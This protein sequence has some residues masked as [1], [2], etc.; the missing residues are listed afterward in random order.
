VGYRASAGGCCGPVRKSARAATTSAAQITTLDNWHKRHTHYYRRWAV[1]CRT[2]L[3]LIPSVV[4]VPLAISHDEA[5]VAWSTGS[6]CKNTAE[7]QRLLP[8]HPFVCI[9]QSQSS[10]HSEHLEQWKHGGHGQ[11]CP[12]QN[13]DLRL[14][15]SDN[16]LNTTY[17]GTLKEVT[18]IMINV[19]LVE[20][21]L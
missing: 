5:K 9:S 16:Q 13:I 8:L 11:D 12:A 15:W 10:Q 17:K 19:M 20:G 3:W 14:I 4:R 6:N 21:S 18:A 1:W 2:L 7:C